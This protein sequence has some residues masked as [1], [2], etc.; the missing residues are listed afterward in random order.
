MDN[1]LGLAGLLAFIFLTGIG[2]NGLIGFFL[3]QYLN[4]SYLDNTFLIG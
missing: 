3:K 4:L 1:E 2:A